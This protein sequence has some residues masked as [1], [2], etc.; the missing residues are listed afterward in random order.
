MAAGL[1]VVVSDWNGY[2]DTVREG[3]DGFR[4]PTL[5]PASTPSQSLQC[6]YAA[7]QIDYDAYLGLTSLQVSIDHR[8]LVQVLKLLFDS[9]ELRRE[10][11]ANAIKRAHDVYDWSRVIPRY[12]DLWADLNERRLAKQR[13]TTSIGANYPSPERPDPFGFFANYPTKSLSLGDK[14]KVSGDDMTIL[15]SQYS[16]IASLKMFSSYMP[17][18]LQPSQIERLLTLLVSSDM[19]IADISVHLEAESPLVLR[20]VAFLIKIGL[21]EKAAS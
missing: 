16:Q 13:S 20:T 7:G 18:V 11:S 21:L 12:E 9:E 6:A 1:P 5:S 14:V 15:L 17:S 4:V 10:M 8:R 19:A 3:V 2:K